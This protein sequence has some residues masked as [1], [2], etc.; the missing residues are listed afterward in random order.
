MSKPTFLMEGQDEEPIEVYPSQ[1]CIPVTVPT[2][3]L[4]SPPSV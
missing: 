3:R 2:G 1:G 4:G